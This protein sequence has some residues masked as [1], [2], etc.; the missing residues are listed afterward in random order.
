MP[1]SVAIVVHG[2]FHAFDLARGLLECGCQVHLI[3]SFSA[4]EVNAEPGLEAVKVY[5]L[6]WHR[7]AAR[8][9]GRLFPSGPPVWVERVLHAGFGCHAA[10]RLR[11]IAGVELVYAFAGVAAESLRL[12][13]LRSILAR[14][15][16]HIRM[17]HQLLADL[18][19]RVGTRVEK[20]S[21]WRIAR[22]EYEYQHC[23]RIRVLSRFCAESFVAMGV[24]EARLLHLPS[25]VALERFQPEARAIAERRARSEQGLPLR[26]L[27]VGSVCARKGE[28]CLRQV[29]A[30]I[31][32]EMELRVIGEQLAAPI[33][34]DWS[35]RV[36]RLPR[37]AEA[38]LPQHYAWA[39][40][41]LFPSIEEGLPAVLLQAALSGL[42]LCTT[43]NA[44]GADVLIDGGGELI[45]VDAVADFV[46]ALRRA[47]AERASIHASAERNRLA[48]QQRSRREVA[49]ALLQAVAA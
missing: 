27:Y 49:Q 11:R 1:R 29:C 20:P 40:V 5:S 47:A 46:A 19:R 2:R 43:A 10:A 16:T 25:T 37:V 32:E 23:D 4:A 41:F 44:G 28:W 9:A 24:P 34:P 12:P 42:Y 15:S 18:E 22:E 7:W 35:M 6:R 3:T 36:Q 38:E 45:A 48:Q 21:T 30:A 26:V 39:D 17:Q 13:H 33:G 14:G 8:I 31:A